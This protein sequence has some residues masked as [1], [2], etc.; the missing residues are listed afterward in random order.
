[1]SQVVI[2]AA[3]TVHTPLWITAVVPLVIDVILKFSL[4][5]A[6]LKTN[7]LYKPAVV[8]KVKVVAELEIVA[9]EVYSLFSSSCSQNL[10]SGKFLDNFSFIPKSE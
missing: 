4:V 1:M 3:G 7:P 6:F 10:Y 5:T 8:T 9:L 2:A